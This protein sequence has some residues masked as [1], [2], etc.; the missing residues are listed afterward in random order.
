MRQKKEALERE[1]EEKRRLAEKLAALQA[2][3]VHGGINLIEANKA[4]QEKLRRQ[5]L[6]LQQRQEMER[7]LKQELLAKEEEKLA[8]EEQYASIQE[9]AQIKTK[10]LQKLWNKYQSARSEIEDLAKE[11]QEERE[12]YLFTIRKLEQEIKLA[13]KIIDHFIPPVELI[14]I[15]KKAT[16]NEEED[17]WIIQNIFLAGN[18]SRARQPAEELKRFAY[19]FR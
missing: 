15:Q 18:N 17:E 4:Q 7:R 10:K 3:V 12:D 13:N 9:E 1:Q 5:E 14:R 19:R 6:E 2:R 8:V 16:Y 11:F